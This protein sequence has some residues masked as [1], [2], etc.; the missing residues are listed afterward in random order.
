MNVHDAAV[1]VH[2][3]HHLG[4]GSRKSEVSTRSCK[5]E[6]LHHSKLNTLWGC[7]ATV[8]ARVPE[9]SC[10]TAPSGDSYR[11]ATSATGCKLLQSS[12]QA[13]ISRRMYHMCQH[14]SLVNA[15]A[16]PTACG[17]DMASHT[18]P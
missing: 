18:S 12:M 17:P 5:R 8:G 14:A 11:P 3:F 4:V 7:S 16:S 10:R 2:R 1:R 15:E 9:W 6:T 13:R